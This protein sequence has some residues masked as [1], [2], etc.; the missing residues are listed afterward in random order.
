MLGFVL[1]LYRDYV[2]LSIGVIE[3]LC[4]AYLEV[5]IGAIEGDIGNG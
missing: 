1:G 4:W 2:G 5:C 3:G